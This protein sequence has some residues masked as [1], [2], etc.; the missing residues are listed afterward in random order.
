MDEF[1]FEHSRGGRLAGKVQT[2]LCQ[3][4]RREPG[5]LLVTPTP[6]GGSRADW[7]AAATIDGKGSGAIQPQRAASTLCTT[8]AGEIPSRQASLGVQRQEAFMQGTHGSE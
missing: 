5:R 8:A 4:C 6:E 2:L 7:L 3:R 1:S